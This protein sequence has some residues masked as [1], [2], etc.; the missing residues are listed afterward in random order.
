MVTVPLPV[1]QASFLFV[2][3]ENYLNFWGLG[4]VNDSDADRYYTI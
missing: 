1:K 4:S 2:A 3:D